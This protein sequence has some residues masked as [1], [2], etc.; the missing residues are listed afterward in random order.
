M[1]ILIPH[2][3][4]ESEIDRILT[5]AEDSFHHQDDDGH[6]INCKPNYLPTVAM[7]AF[8]RMGSHLP[9]PFNGVDPWMKFYRLGGQQRGIVLPHMDQ[10]FV[11]PNGKTATWSVLFYLG[12]DYQGGETVFDGNRVVAH[13]APGTALVFPHSL[14]HEGRAVTSGTK[15]VL[16]TD[17]F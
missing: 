3:L 9:R 1:E 13:P 16:K 4:T 17:L 5:Y 12:G 7:A 10:D 8:D 15:L 6:A 2:V 11:C 14:A